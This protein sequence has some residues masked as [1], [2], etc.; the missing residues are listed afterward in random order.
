MPAYLVVD[1]TIT[2]PDT[3]EDYKR[4]V[5]PTIVNHGG[6]FLAR[7]GA[8]EIVEAG[9]RWSPDRM[10]IVEFPSME[11]LRAWYDS[12]DYAPAREIRFRSAKSTL[13]ALDGVAAAPEP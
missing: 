12:A 10:V 6:R 1:E 4:A 9:G 2:D 8:M 7:G 5:L 11:A 3:F 13:V